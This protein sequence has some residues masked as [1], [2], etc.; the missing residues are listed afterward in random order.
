[1]GESRVSHGV[2]VGLRSTHAEGLEL[3]R[4]VRPPVWRQG[5]SSAVHVL[6]SL[7][8]GGARQ[9]RGVTAFHV[10]YGNARQ[11]ARTHDVE[12]VRRAFDRDLALA[13]A[14]RARHHV[15]VHAGV[16][17]IGG[18]AVVFPGST[19]AGKTT[20]TRALL[21]RGARYL[22]DDYAVFDEEGQVVPW[23]EALS[24]REPGEVRGR[25]QPLAAHGIVPA[26]RPVPV[27]AVVL[28]RYQAGARFQ[29]A[30]GGASSG[31]LGLMAHAVAGRLRPAIVL[32]TLARAAGEALVLEGVRG[33][34]ADAAKTIV[35]L[36]QA[37][38]T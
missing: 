35:S 37:G 13:I 30:R 36:V 11:L 10:L 34:A 7:V 26:R 29:P 6:Y 3:L 14:R 8:W 12:R 19:R 33:E 15:F 38:R 22:S 4:S 27:R 9:R 23:P 18:G 17:A 25:K 24:I 2:R 5:R 32:P 28:T 20:L 1:M 16:V 21:E 31:I